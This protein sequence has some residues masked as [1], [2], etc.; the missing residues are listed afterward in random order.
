[1]SCKVS[2]LNILAAGESGVLCIQVIGSSVRC[3]GE[4]GRR[5]AGV[6]ESVAEEETGVLAERALAQRGSSAGK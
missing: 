1:M 6:G 5:D 4:R 3:S 2:W